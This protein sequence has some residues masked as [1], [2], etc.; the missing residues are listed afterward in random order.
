MKKLDL[1]NKFDAQGINYKLYEHEPLFSVKESEDKRGRISGT[2]TKNLFLKN[3]KNYFCLFS[4]KENSIIN[5]KKFSK[6]IYASNLSFAREE[7]LFKY[8]GVKP[9]SVSPYALLNDTKNRVHFYLEDKL[10]KCHKINFHPLMNTTTI[11]VITSDFIKFMTENKKK[12]NIFSL[13]D[14]KLIEII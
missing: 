2:H 7:Y 4:C 3:K 1:L 6:A 11:S 12:I 14:Y 5:L 10:Y 8:L 13:Q 9:G